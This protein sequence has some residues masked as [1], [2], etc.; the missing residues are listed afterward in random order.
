MVKIALDAG[1]ATNTAGKRTPDGEREWSFNNAVA[2]AA[3]R[4]LKEYEGVE[5]LRVDDRSGKRDVPLKER[6]DAA[7]RWGADYYVSIHHNAMTGAWH[8]GGGVETFVHPNAS[9]ASK[10]LAKAVHP[11]IVS[12][13]G[14]GD[15]GVKVANHHVTRETKM[16]AI[17]TEGGFMD[18]R[19]DIVAMRNPAKMDAQGRAIA[20][21]LAEVASLSKAVKKASVAP[22]NE[23]GASSVEYEKD[24]KVG[25]ALK[26]DFDKAVANGIT[27]GTYPHRPATRAE[28][29]V[30]I[31]R[32]IAK[33][34]ER[35]K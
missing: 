9:E 6:T 34:E 25:G 33:L 15:R 31:Q 13:M 30:M 21:G 16:P 24:A 29:A 10:R 27:D 2:I 28:V 14:I 32:A 19:K 22:K 17:L 12:A 1:H 18:S 20:E 26:A 8:N 3:E 4:Y 23:G 7:N 11:R 35:F 5:V